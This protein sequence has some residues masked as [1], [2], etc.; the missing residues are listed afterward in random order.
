MWAIGTGNAASKEDV[1]KAHIFIKKLLKEINPESETAV[2]YGGSTSP[3]NI[4]DLTSIPEVNG[5]LIG[6]ASLNIEKFSKMIE[7]CS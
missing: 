6:G 3:D 4:E 7:I 1:S 5:A 2:L